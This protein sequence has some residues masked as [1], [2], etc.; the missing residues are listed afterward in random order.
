MNFLKKLFLPITLPLKFIQEHFKAMIFVLILFLLFAPQGD[1][2][3]TSNNL[4]EIQ[5]IGPIMDA[6]EIVTQIDD[7]AQNKNIKGV[8]LVVDSPGGAVAPS[9]EIAYAVKRLGAKKPIAVYAKGTI[10]S[11]SYYASI[12]ADK[13]I[14]NP[15][16]M[17]GSIGVIMQGTDLSGIMDK[18]GIKTQVVKAGK[19]KQLGT[20]DRPWTDFEVNELNKVIQGT[21]DMFSRDVAQARHL[22]YKKRDLYANAHIFTAYQAQEI[23][24]VDNVTVLYNAREQL[25]IMSNI[26]KE[27]A[28]WNKEDKFDKFMKKLAATSAVTLH[29]YFPSLILK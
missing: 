15:G 6:T 7:A 4:Q 24:L 16:S 3:L 10:A 17:V 13:I 28:I 25:R 29:T 22:D 2:D 20:S 23:G 9:I 14:V 21:Y 19:Y 1:E 27:D 8:L 26:K 18:I 11:G 12:W 5:L